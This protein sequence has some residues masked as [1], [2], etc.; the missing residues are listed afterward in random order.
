MK[1]KIGSV[2]LAALLMVILL[3]PAMATV[4]VKYTIADGAMTVEIPKRYTVVTTDM[5]ENENYSEIIEDMKQNSTYLVASD[6]DTGLLLTIS[7]HESDGLT[8][9]S[10]GGT[11]RDAFSA[12]VVR[13]LE[14]DGNTV[15][16]SGFYQNGTV[17]S[18]VLQWDD[19][20]GVQSLRYSTVQNG[21]I[22]NFRLSKNGVIDESEAET[23]KNIVDSVSFLTATAGTQSGASA[24]DLT[25]DSGGSTGASDILTLY[26]A[27]YLIGHLI[28]AFLLCCVPIAIYRYGI[29][30]KPVDRK[31]AAQ[32]AIIYGGI[33]LA[34]LIVGRVAK[35]GSVNWVVVFAFAIATIINFQM[36]TRSKQRKGQ[37]QDNGF[38]TEPDI[39]GQEMGMSWN[40]EHYVP[41]SEAQQDRM[42]G[43]ELDRINAGQTVL[44]DRVEPVLRC[45]QCGRTLQSGVRFCAN[46]G[47]RVEF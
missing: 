37:E 12:E 24:P 22:I 3:V 5:Q 33:L 25:S 16:D 35:N 47:E 43:H 45:R 9:E 23:I 19:N 30:K 38:N 44:L 26:L 6:P 2:L 41:M 7:M 14:N 32:I 28:G 15:L 17:I 31:K 10:M 36:L 39:S 29:V 11:E 42:P 1:R 13:E 20:D 46:C 4:V 18:F 27:G 21:K 8:F 40:S 34:I